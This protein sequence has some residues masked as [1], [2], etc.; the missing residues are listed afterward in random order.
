VDASVASHIWNECIC[1]D[2][3]GTTRVLVTN[4]F[5][6]SS[7][8]ELRQIVVMDGCQVVEQGT[9]AELM[10]VLESRYKR[11]ADVTTTIATHKNAKVEPRSSTSGRLS[12][13]RTAEPSRA[14]S[15]MTST[16]TKREGAV[17]LST[18][19]WFLLRIGSCPHLFL[20]VLSSWSYDAM[21]QI[22][23]DL[24]L[25]MWVSGRDV[26]GEQTYEERL[27]VWLGLIAFG[28]LCS[29]FCR[30]LWAI[31]ALKVGRTVHLQVLNRL[32]ECPMNFFNTTPSGRVLNR[33]G[34]DQM[35]LEFTV[36]L[37][38]EVF[39]LLLMG[40]LNI[41]VI[42]IVTSPWLAL[43]FPMLMPPMWLLCALLR[44]TLRES[45]R[46]WM[47]TKSPVFHLME[48]VLSVA[49]T[50]AAFGR[51]EDQEEKF[52]EAARK[53]NEWIYTKDLANRWFEMMLT[54]LSSL[55]SGSLVLLLT[56][57]R[58]IEVDPATA[59]VV[60]VLSIQFPL[61]ARL[62]AYMFVQ[63]EAAMAS[64]ERLSEYSDGLQQEAARIRQ[65]DAKLSSAGWPS[66][67]PDLVFEDVFFRYQPHL[68]QVLV[69]LSMRIEAAAKVG[70][71]GRT[72]SG[73]STLVSCLF[74]LVELEAGR[75]LIGGQ[76]IAFIGL[77]LLRRR[78]TIVPQDPLLFSG[79]LRRNLDVLHTLNDEAILDG[80]ARCGFADTLGSLPEGLDTTVAE[81]GGNFSV[82][83]RQVFCLTRALLRAASIL[84]LDEA[85]ANVDP[86][87]DLL[88]QKVIRK[89][90]REC[91]ALTIAHRLHTV[92]DSDRIA[93]LDAGRLAQ[94]DSPQTLLQ[95]GGIFQELAKEAGVAG[96]EIPLAV[97]AI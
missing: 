21:G 72:G 55:V 83:E 79:S 78:V 32:L 66:K 75:V 80:L 45:I 74:R 47:M 61:F 41:S 81:N 90:F 27:V 43:V 77:T 13:R 7:H 9:H 67:G 18:V 3:A 44:R 91:T 25:S 53:N 58:G 28:M 14:V 19:V 2:L 70:I 29:S 54:P 62:V 24:Y 12:T 35:T 94:F 85:T 8:P 87:N 56:Q 68:P 97:N 36:S 30:F 84:V 20:V 31:S 34:E 11:M 4:Q 59:G 93:V 57:V 17:T 73:K 88:I 89:E 65:D 76:D 37:F 64:V 82:G 92:L 10:D 63:L 15:R 96:P 71:V 6:F 1:G 48:E 50:L 16:E 40:V 52:F 69:G 42:V 26:F 51:L 95:E 60:L 23:P 33:L 38:L 46:F 86:E 39:L 22:V 49:P 5:H